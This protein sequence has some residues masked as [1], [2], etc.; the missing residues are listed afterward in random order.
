MSRRKTIGKKRKF[1]VIANDVIYNEQF[2]C[3]SGN[4]VTEARKT[5]AELKRI[6]KGEDNE[7]QFSYVIKERLSDGTLVRWNRNAKHQISF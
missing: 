6:D 4:D 2:I 1:F 3:Y 5:I 7:G